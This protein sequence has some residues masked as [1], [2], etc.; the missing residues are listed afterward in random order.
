MLFAI[1]CGH[2]PLVAMNWNVVVQ[3]R[4]VP[5]RLICLNTWSPAGGTLWEGLEGV[6]LEEVWSWL[7]L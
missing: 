5:H 3:M 2:K 7:R 6:A 1:S 4:N